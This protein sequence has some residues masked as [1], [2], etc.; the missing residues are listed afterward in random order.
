MCY[1]CCQLKG[2]PFKAEKA[3]GRL[4]L[5][6]SHLLSQLSGEPLGPLA[7]PKPFSLPKSAMLTAILCSYTE[8]PQSHL[9]YQTQET[10]ASCYTMHGSH[11]APYDTRPSSHSAE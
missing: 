4:R 7:G 5:A 2:D 3:V 10:A 8:L 9:H 11:S 1:R 6:E